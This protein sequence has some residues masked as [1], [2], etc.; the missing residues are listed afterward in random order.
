MLAQSTLLLTVLCLILLWTQESHAAANSVETDNN[1]KSQNPYRHQRRRLRLARRDNPSAADALIAAAVPQQLTTA[2]TLPTLPDTTT[3][4][5]GIPPLPALPNLGTV[6]PAP[7][8]ALPPAAG[9]PVFGG[10]PPPPP[11]P[12]AAAPSADGK[13]K[14]EEDEEEEDEDED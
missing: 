1:W 7:A 5:Q 8:P 2:P 12:S 3:L 10:S 11:P 9:L 14:K 4:F 6:A 13:K